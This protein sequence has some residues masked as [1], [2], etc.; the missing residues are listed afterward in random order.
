MKWHSLAAA[1]VGCSFGVIAACSVGPAYHRPPCRSCS[2]TCAISPP[3]A[4]AA[5]HD[6]TGVWPSADWWHGFGSA[7]LDE[8]IGEAERSND[9]LAGAIARVREADAQVRIAGAALLPSLDV[10]AT[11]ERQRA[12][13]SGLGPRVFN[14]FGPELSASYELDFW[15][16]NRSALRATEESAMPPGRPRWPAATISKPWR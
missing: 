15:G 3:A 2:A 11:A 10:G 16:K 5:V 4:S 6:P 9:D 1:I 14:S 12:Q 13:V 7:K 8:L